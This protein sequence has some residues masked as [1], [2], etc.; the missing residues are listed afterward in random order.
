MTVSTALM[1][2]AAAVLMFVLVP[3]WLYWLCLIL[4]LI[5]AV[6]TAAA[7]YFLMSDYLVAMMLGALVAG[8][9]AA[10]VGRKQEQVSA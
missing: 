4:L 5:D 2:I 6:A 1:V 9:L 10:A 8:L 3:K 7:G